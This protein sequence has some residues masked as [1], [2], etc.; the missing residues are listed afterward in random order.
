MHKTENYITDF[1]QTQILR[2]EISHISIY[3]SSNSR[4]KISDI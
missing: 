2:Q 1:F 3:L 4:I